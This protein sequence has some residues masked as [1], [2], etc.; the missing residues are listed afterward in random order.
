MKVYRKMLDSDVW[1]TSY[2][3]RCIFLWLL[4]SVDYEQRKLPPGE[5]LTTY[6]KVAAAVAPKYGKAPTQKQVRTAL[7][8]LRS[9]EVVATDRHTNGQTCLH[10]KVLHW[11]DYQG[12]GRADPLATLGR[13]S[14]DGRAPIVKESRSKNQEVVTQ[15]DTI[16]R[17]KPSEIDAR[18]ADFWFLYPK[19][20]S[21]GHARKMYES[22]LKKTDPD[23]ILRALRRQLPE[24]KSKERQFIPN[25]GTWLNGERWEDEVVLAGNTPSRIFSSSEELAIDEAL[26]LMRAGDF[27]GAQYS[28]DE[29][30]YQEV[31][32]RFYA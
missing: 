30:L 21:K 2:L 32:R 24:L 27:A 10:I 31:R 4:L 1:G 23:T 29:D 17:L 9:A 20:V 8:S 26:K 5:M 22:A 11:Q 15:V 19:K 14:G 25:P 18:F 16:S 7:D 13:S 12:N 28:V 6:A 3:A